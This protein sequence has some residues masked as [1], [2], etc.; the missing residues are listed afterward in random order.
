MNHM[1]TP[2]D[3]NWKEYWH[4]REKDKAHQS[5]TRQDKKKARKRFHKKNRRD[6]RQITP[7]QEE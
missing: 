5:L 1:P 6:A 3:R 4:Q 2:D 7:D